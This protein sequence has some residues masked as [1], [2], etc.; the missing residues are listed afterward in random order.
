MTLTSKPESD[1]VKASFK[2]LLTDQTGCSENAY[3]CS[4]EHG[5]LSACCSLGVVKWL[6][7]NRR[8]PPHYSKLNVC[9]VAVGHAGWS[10][11]G[12]HTERLLQAIG[13]ESG[14]CIGR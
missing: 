3:Q 4:L 11:V 12:M 13:R 5:H 7:P 1:F 8:G 10:P 9:W 6:G 14:M 2:S